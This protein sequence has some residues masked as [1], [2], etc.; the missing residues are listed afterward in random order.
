MKRRKWRD[1]DRYRTQKQYVSRCRRSIRTTDRRY[2]LPE[3]QPTPGNPLILKLYDQNIRQQYGH[4]SKRTIRKCTDHGTI[5]QPK[6]Y[7]EIYRK[8][9]GDLRSSKNRDIQRLKTLVEYIG[10]GFF[11]CP[12]R[13]LRE[14]GIFTSMR[15]SPSRHRNERRRTLDD[16]YYRPDHKDALF[17]FTDPIRSLEGRF[18]WKKSLCRRDTQESERRDRKIGHTHVSSR[19]CGSLDDIRYSQRRRY[20]RGYVRE[21]DP[22]S[23]RLSIHGTRRKRRDLGYGIAHRSHSKRSRSHS[24][25]GHYRQD[26]QK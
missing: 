18:L 15:S 19:L 24:R 13:T 10:G 11:V 16:R 4:H 7:G 14:V 21:R 20:F 6:K 26:I 8:R 12:G 22:F 9:Y 17:Y 3:L 23:Y 5:E 2:Y 25:P 1:D